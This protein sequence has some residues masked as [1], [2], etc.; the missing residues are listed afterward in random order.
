MKL[1]SGMLV[2]FSTVMIPN[3]RKVGLVLG[4]KAE[5]EP[6]SVIVFREHGILEDVWRT[7]ENDVNPFTG[8]KHKEIKQ[9]LKLMVVMSSRGEIRKYAKQL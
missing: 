4:H 1:E 6:V 9:M 8:G 2:E 7:E 5:R 3:R